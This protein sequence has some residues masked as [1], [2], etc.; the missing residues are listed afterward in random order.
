MDP[1][2]ARVDDREAFYS[3]LGR[4]LAHMQRTSEE[5]RRAFC[6]VLL[7]QVLRFGPRAVDASVLLEAFRL[8]LV[9]GVADTD[10]A[11]VFRDYAR[12]L[13]GQRDLGLVLR[14]ILELFERARVEP[15][16]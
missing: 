7:D 5:T 6:R 2:A 1:E 4:H 12:R 15:R 3:A 16:A 10:T 9:D 8:G 11:T 13:R 14:P